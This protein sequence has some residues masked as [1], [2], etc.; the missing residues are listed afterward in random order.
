MRR[1]TSPPAMRVL[2]ICSSVFLISIAASRPASAQAGPQQ[3]T[4][5][6]ARPP[7]APLA[8]PNA[9]LIS[10]EV[11]GDGHVTFRL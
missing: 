10:P 2:L 1:I 5:G 7:Q 6:A 9:T 11:T 8:T 4:P 3:T